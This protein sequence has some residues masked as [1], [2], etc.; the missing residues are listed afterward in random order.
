MENMSDLKNVIRQTLENKGI[1]QKMKAQIRAE[2]F[3]SLEGNDPINQV[4]KPPEI[5]LACELIRE[6]LISLD[7]RN[8][9]AVFCEESGPTTEM[10][11]HRDLIAS[12]LGLKLSNEDKSVP[13]LLMIIKYLKDMKA[14][15]IDEEVLR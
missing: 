1:L 10:S 3:L 14:Q 2:V 12:E 8:S 4:E 7:Y 13:L 6:L 11:V 15:R 9:L 5:F